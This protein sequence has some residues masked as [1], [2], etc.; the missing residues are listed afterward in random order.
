MVFIHAPRG[1]TD[2]GDRDDRHHHHPGRIVR[3]AHTYRA[4]HRLY[5]DTNGQLTDVIYG[6]EAFGPAA[7]TYA[8][9]VTVG[10]R[11][12]RE[13]GITQQQAQDMLDDYA[14]GADSQLIQDRR[15]EREHAAETARMYR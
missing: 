9:C 14:A 7:G 2:Q 5:F 3:T 4:G 11:G 13:P 1:V 10:A 8:V 6:P 15:G 12:G